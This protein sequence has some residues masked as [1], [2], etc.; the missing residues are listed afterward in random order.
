M[1]MVLINYYLKSQTSEHREHKDVEKNMSKNSGGCF[2]K[3]QI[4]LWENWLQKLGS[5][6]HH[7][8]I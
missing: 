1:V 2:S 8:I 4:I 5:F 6:F 3:T 7:L